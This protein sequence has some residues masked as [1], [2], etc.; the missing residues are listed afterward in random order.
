M[1][2]AFRANGTEFLETIAVVHLAL[3]SFLYKKTRSGQQ[4]FASGDYIFR[5]Q[6]NTQ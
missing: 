3:E 1:C 4:L 2:R 5:T 6:G